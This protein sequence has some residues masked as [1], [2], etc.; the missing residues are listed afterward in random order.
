MIL[1]T[2]SQEGSFSEIATRLRSEIQPSEKTF[3]VA[4]ITTPEI[5]NRDQVEEIIKQKDDADEEDEDGEEERSEESLGENERE[6][7]GKQL[8]QEQNQ[9]LDHARN[10]KEVP[11][12]LS[13][14][15]TTH[16]AFS[17]E[18]PAKLR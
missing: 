4:V 16:S 17:K 15:N 14:R 7:Q 11:A 2:G 12:S 1:S 10:D 6:E 9:D 18:V 13:P 3:P 5:E 8:D